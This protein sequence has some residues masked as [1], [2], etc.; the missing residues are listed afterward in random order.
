MKKFSWLTG[1]MMMIVVGILLTG[2]SR[3]GEQKESTKQTELLIGYFALPGGPEEKMQEIVKIFEAEHPEIKVKTRSAGYSEFFTKLKNELA[4]GIAPDVW[5]SDGVFVQE[6]A[7]RGVLLEL[8][9]LA[10]DVFTKEKFYGIEESKDNDGRIWGIPQGIQ[11]GV[12][13]YNK[14]MFNQNGLSFPT[15]DWTLDDLRKTALKLSKD[16]N[17]DSQ[18]DVWGVSMPKDI[19]D[20]W[21]PIIKQF[22]G[23]IL[24]E[25][26][27]KC[28][29]D[30][31]KS[32]AALEFISA[33][34][35]KD[36][37]APTTI[38]YGGTSLSNLFPAEKVAMTYGLYSR[39][40]AANQVNINYDVQVCPQGPSGDR[41]S[42][43][44]ANSWVINKKASS[45]KQNAA[46]EWIKFYSG[47]KAQEMMTELGEAVPMNREVTD[48]PDFLKIKDNPVNR[49]AFVKSLAFAGTLDQNGCWAEWINKMNQQ[50]EPIYS[51]KKSVNQI[52]PNAIKEVQVVLDRFYKK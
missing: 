30:N 27:T 19:T 28:V 12:L 35:M 34:I 8:T 24:D 2:C 42:S 20:G 36:K 6:Y 33:L 44:I 49:S 52:L 16:T 32:V 31:S 47:K 22:G 39:I 48:G 13:Y 15:E 51:G 40:I 25:S 1:I 50:L 10:K 43:L 26:K 5:L 23:Q 45:A 11:V 21:F 4:A 17:G 41:F 46:W 9:D 18:L 38:Q 3:Q 7:E 37:S 14:D 29:L